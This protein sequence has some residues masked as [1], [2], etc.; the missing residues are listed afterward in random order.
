MLPVVVVDQMY[1]FDA[2]SLLRSL[3]R[4]KEIAAS[5]FRVTAEEV[6]NRVM[7]LADNA[8]GADEHRALNYL[9]VRYPALYALVAERHLQN[10]S[11]TGVDVRPSRL[12]ASRQIVDVIASFTH[13]QTD[14]TE[15]LFVRVDVTEEFP[16]LVT[17]LSPLYER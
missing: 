3:T 14:V 2:D 8:G 5:E 4:P 11:W 9:A 10:Y 12:S 16:F 6:F 15:R 17:K 1:W 13:R 7:Q